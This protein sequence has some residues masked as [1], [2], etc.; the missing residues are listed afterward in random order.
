MGQTRPITFKVDPDV[1]NELEDEAEEEDKTKS[2]YIREVVK[3]R[4]SSEK[5]I[6]QLNDQ[7]REHRG[8]IE[9]LEAE[10]ET[11]RDEIAALEE[12]LGKEDEKL[13]EREEK[14]TN[15]RDIKRTQRRI[16]TLL[17][18]DVQENADVLRE[19]GQD[20][21]AIEGE[22]ETLRERHGVFID[23]ARTFF[24]DVNDEIHRL[25]LNIEDARGF[26][27]KVWEEFRRYHKRDF[28]ARVFRR[29]GLV[30]SRHNL[31]EEGPE[32]SD[33]PAEEH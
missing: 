17:E 27:Q 30:P 13:R 12:K 11:K 1:A 2:Q 20:L 10:L 18:E 5:A 8:Q 4:H 15:L 29:L 23:E 22:M 9:D 14:L 19:I 26:S 31:P 16:E 24:D 21:N 7:I 32:L 33:N 25:A 28:R 6:E 3:N